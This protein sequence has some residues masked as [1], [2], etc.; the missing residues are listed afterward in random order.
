MV[1]W[2]VEIVDLRARP[3]PDLSRRYET[4]NTTS[5]RAKALAFGKVILEAMPD[6]AEVYARYRTGFSLAISGRNV[7]YAEWFLPV[8]HYLY[9]RIVRHDKGFDLPPF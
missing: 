5:A 9:V 6:G 3:E 2:T 1:N 7:R 8:S 4:T